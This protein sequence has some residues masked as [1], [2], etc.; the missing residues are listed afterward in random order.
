MELLCCVVREKGHN[1][2]NPKPFA[3][4]TFPSTFLAVIRRV[5]SVTPYNPF[6]T[7][8]WSSSVSGDFF[9]F[10]LYFLFHY[11]SVF[12]FFSHLSFRESFPY[13][14][15]P[16]LNS[17]LSSVSWCDRGNNPSSWA[18]PLSSLDLVP[19]G[20]VQPRSQGLSSSSFPGS[21]ILPP[22]GGGKK[23]DPGN[24]VGPSFRFSMGNFD[25]AIH[26]V[27]GGLLTV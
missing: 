22:P 16:T 20:L 6:T 24:E 15:S 8:S 5:I 17:V 13:S 7:D 27:C 21:L 12:F 1:R 23:R 11:K 2:S 4:S 10:R 26:I 3:F 9:P 14:A 18:G 25:F 19:E